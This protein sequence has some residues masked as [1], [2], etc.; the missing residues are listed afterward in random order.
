M[1]FPNVQAGV[2]ELIAEQTLYIRQGDQLPS[3]VMQIV[4]EFGDPINIVGKQ[5]WLTLRVTDQFGTE[6]DWG[7]P[8]ETLILDPANG[9]VVYDWQPGDTDSSNPGTYELTID[10]TDSGTPDFITPTRRDTYIGLRPEIPV[11]N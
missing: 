5:A 8:R 10:I 2:G 7:N 4:D 1:T 3:L 11:P 6:T 9:I